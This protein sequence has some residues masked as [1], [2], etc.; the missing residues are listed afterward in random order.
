MIGGAASTT[1]KLISTGLSGAANATSQL[2]S[3]DPFSYQNFLIAG[4]GGWKSAGTALLPN[5]GISAGT[6]YISSTSG[7]TPISCEIA[8]ATMGSVMAWPL[9]P[10][11]AATPR[12]I[13]AGANARVGYMINDEVNPKQVSASNDVYLVISLD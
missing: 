11:I 2:L 6:A 9:L 3:D 12:L 7:G 5:V 1:T 10:G 4:I 13:G 8:V